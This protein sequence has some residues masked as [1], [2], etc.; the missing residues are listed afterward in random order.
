MNKSL[1]Q[2]TSNA[3]YQADYQAIHTIEISLS[4]S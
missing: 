1:P 4:L 3:E 2:S